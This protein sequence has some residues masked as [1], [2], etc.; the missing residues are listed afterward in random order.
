[1]SN[2]STV[3][4]PLTSQDHQEKVSFEKRLEALRKKAVEYSQKPTE[5]PLDHE[6]CLA[7]PNY[8]RWKRWQR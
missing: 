6:L 4:V 7:K 1:M 5:L 3:E 2:Q 8:T